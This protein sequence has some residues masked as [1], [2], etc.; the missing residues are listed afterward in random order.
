MKYQLRGLQASFLLHAILLT[1]LA[2]L[3]HSV[4]QAPKPITLDFI[5]ANDIAADDGA[6]KKEKVPAA[7]S[8]ATYQKTNEEPVTAETRQERPPAQEP[9]RPAALPAPVQPAQVSVPAPQAAQLLSGPVTV[10]QLPVASNTAGKAVVVSSGSGSATGTITEGT[11]IRVGHPDGTVEFGSSAG[12]SFLS[13]ELPAYPPIARR[14][15]KE[16]R[17]LLRLTIDEKGR[18]LQVEAVENPGF[19]FTEAAIEAVRKSSFVPAK[20]DGK[21]VM[22]VAL[23]PVRFQLKRSE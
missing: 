7:K 3:G 8:A 16:A 20:R 13:R 4:T 2:L 19:G 17:V 14:M 12:P 22:V 9:V 6:V 21:P 23:L 5:I 11:A 10:P 15:G 18:L 1:I